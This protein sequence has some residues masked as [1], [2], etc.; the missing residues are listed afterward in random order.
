M[1]DQ[2]FSHSSTTYNQS[3]RLAAMRYIQRLECP[4]TLAQLKVLLQAKDTE[5]TRIRYFNN[6]M[7]HELKLRYVQAMALLH[8]RNPIWDEAN[9]QGLLLENNQTNITYINELIIA[10]TIGIDRFMQLFNEVTDKTI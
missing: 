4:S 10:E 5:N 8:Q 1:L 3:V 6:S 2:Q 9:L 7:Q